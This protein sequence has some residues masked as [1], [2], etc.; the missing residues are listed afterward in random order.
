VI[1]MC[2]FSEAYNATGAIAA[3]GVLNQ[4]GRPDIEALEVLVRE[5]VQNCWDAKRPNEQGIRVDIGRLRLAPDA[6]AE[7]RERV[8]TDPP[9]GLPLDDVLGPDLDLLYFA[10]HGTAGL[11]GPTRADRLDATRPNDFV[12]FVRNIGQPPDKEYGGGSYGFGKAAFYLASRARTI[13]IDTLCEVDGGRLERR[14]IA[15]G[16]GE[17]H[18]EG[19]QPYTG[20]HWWGRMVDGVPEPLV[21]E[22]ASQV[23]RLLGLPDREG[24][25]GMGTTIAVIAPNVMIHE[26]DGT[27]A[28]MEF[29][30]ES[31]LWNFWPRITSAPGGVHST[32]RFKVSDDGRRITIPDP[33]LHP[34]LRGFVEAID[35]LH[36]GSERDPTEADD[37]LV[38]DVP[39]ECHRPIR[40][41]GR[42]VLQRGPTAPTPAATRPTP[43]GAQETSGGLHHVALMR[44]AELV[45]R[46]LRGPEP[47]TGRI[48]Y[49]GA[50]VC[51]LDMD[52]TFRRAEP[53]THDDWI[54][55]FL[56]PGPDRTFVK[57]ALQRIG[58]VCRDAAGYAATGGDLDVE[59]GIPLG[60]FADSLAAL[61]PTLEGPGARRDPR[62]ARSRLRNGPG[63]ASAGG[64]TEG[65]W[66]DGGSADDPNGSSSAG[67]AG[68]EPSSDTRGVVS[69]APGRRP[70]PLIR[71]TEQPRPSVDET[72]RAVVL[73]PFD[74]R[75]RGNNVTLTAK[76]EIMTNDGAQVENE[77]PLGQEHPEVEGWIDPSGRLHVGDSVRL[78]TDAAD[79]AWAAVVPLTDDAMMRVDVSATPS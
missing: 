20:R 8:L 18:E 47:M 38:I 43:Q 29:I 55:T 40:Q 53:P 58:R 78:D 66:F 44:N 14:L 19:G 61:M 65:V 6:A 2:R 28:T 26:E 50:F 72:G 10:D 21:D 25:D 32:M 30:G 51:A 54:P 70:P 45:V 56:E 16:L 69:G 46:Y 76:V 7:I 35:R 23:A 77:A 33:R 48:G 59:G 64:A 79:G 71:T 68:P 27:D 17:K 37:P 1:T 11:G 41:L 62:A 39:I 34:R 57:V 4:L 12:D 22:D 75:S 42:L 74:L 15:C 63:A 49:C 73:Y 31:L 24:P 13:V 67:G 9:A 3:A 36:E 5:A 60:E 52:R